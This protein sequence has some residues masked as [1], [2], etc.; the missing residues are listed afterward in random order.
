MLRLM[1]VQQKLLS[2]FAVVLVLL[3]I[4]V[5]TALW[6]MASI[7]ANLIDI[8]D[9]RYPK[10]ALAYKVSTA[11]LEIRRVIRDGII[12]TSDTQNAA[13]VALIEQLHTQAQA[14]IS[15]MTRLIR[16]PTGRGILAQIHSAD[17]K[18]TRDLPQMETLIKTNQNAAAVA[19]LASTISP[20]NT[21]LAAALK[22]MT[23]YQEQQML[24]SGATAQ[25]SYHTA[26]WTMISVAVCALIVGVLMALTLGWI[27]T[28]PLKKSV[29]LAHAIKAGDLSGQRE[30][31]APSRDEA[32]EI[33]RTMQD[34]RQGLREVV[35]GIH[36]DAGR[37]AAAAKA[38]SASAEQ[39]AAGSHQQAEATS[40]A[41]ATIEQLTVSVN[42][43]AD[44]ADEAAARADA[45]GR[46]ATEGSDAARTSSGEIGL[47]T[48]AMAETAAQMTQL[49][50][51]IRHIDHVVNV[52]RGLADQTNL[53]ALNA[54]I[55]AARAGE[56]G[57]GFAVVA[58]EVRK[59]AEHTTRSAGEITAMIN[60][61]QSGVNQVTDSMGRS[62]SRAGVVSDTAEKTSATMQD[63]ES[64]TRA[65]AS[66]ITVI[67]GAL[68]EQRSAS[69][70]LAGSMEMVARMAEENSATVRSLAT[71][72]LQ[73]DGLSQHLQTVVTRFRL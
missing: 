65:I 37:V 45:A 32:I 26:L 17:D 69:L 12:G 71:A 47:V 61:I 51:D 58:D 34:M 72:S 29:R 33:A 46:L 35:S 22:R 14:D 73:L 18:L 66:A 49:Q 15:D 38:L 2:G 8:T 25:A 52:I 28:T 48:G 53:L 67:D 43:V 24:Q 13:N 30:H 59:L 3:A 41:A 19:Y 60:T 36:D 4:V 9:S 27:I 56:Q 70:G 44:S 7:N 16:T 6:K 1:S 40:S 55:E 31:I 5:G 10:L 20:D 63:I 54:A 39:I 62:L 11:Y 50:T 21:A 42:H 57:R 64:G 23:Q 68:A